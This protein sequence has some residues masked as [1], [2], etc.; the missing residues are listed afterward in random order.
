MSPRSGRAISVVIQ[1]A[2]SAP[3]APP[4]AKLRA[5]ARHALAAAE[6]GGEITIRIVEQDESADLNSRY[7]GKEG[8]T[9][10]LS[11][12]AQVPDLPSDETLPI[13][14][15]VIC[16]GVVAAEAAQQGKALEAHWAHM[17]VHGA[18]HLAGYDHENPQDAHVME[19]L[20]RK[21]LNALGFPDPWLASGRGRLQDTD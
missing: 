10:V 12:P 15:V 18:L 14:D 4:P 1:R 11:F 20:E 16:A 17:V 5:W 8:P 3:G 6:R 7:R 13:G 2:A 21:L 19:L 9:N